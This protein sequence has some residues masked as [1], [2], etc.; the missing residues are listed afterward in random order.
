MNT[1]TLSD[2][3]KKHLWHP[4]TRMSTWLDS[5]PL[6]I[7]R[8]EGCYLVD[9]EGRRYLDGVS[10]LWVNLHGHRRPEIDEAIRNQLDR[11]SHSTMLGLSSPPAIELAARLVKCT[12]PSLQRVFYSDNGSTAVEAALKMAYQYWQIVGRPA[13]QRFIALEDAYHGDTLGSVSV[14]GMD[15]FHRIFHPLL[16]NVVRAPSPYWYRYAGGDDPEA[17]RDHCLAELHRLLEKHHHELAAL[18]IEPLVQGAAGMIVQPDGYLKQV[19]ALCREHEV[20]VIFDEVAVG[21]GRTGTLFAG[22]QEEVEPDLLALAKGISGGYLPLAATLSTS[23]LFDA[24]RDASELHTFFHG[25]SYTGNPLACAAG[26]A[27]LD[28]FENESLATRLP[29]KARRLGR[30]LGA[31]VAP[32]AHCGQIRQ[33][34]LMVGIEL[35]NNRQTR[36]PYSQDRL[37]GAEVCAR[38]RD[39]GVLLR[40]LGP[41]IVL[42]PPLSIS[43]DELS[44]L[45][46]ATARGIAEVT[47]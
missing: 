41:V 13:K 39:F 23:P 16:F 26:L 27:S 40:P 46:T 33:K 45:V 17:C 10:S 20:L 35:V 31:H 6:I 36:A 15:L 42:V 3:D 9:T 38:V 22:S 14:G 18:V 8:A 19:V 47:Q 43:D 5:D 32:L 30:L 21:F 24:F 37:I 4:F 29:E 34:G 11:V 1:P 2:L 7:E 12:Y 44:L 25:H 28:I